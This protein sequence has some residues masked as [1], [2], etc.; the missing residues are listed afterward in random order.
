MQ[1]KKKTLYFKRNGFPLYFKKKW[2]GGGGGEN[3]T[4]GG[5]VE[6]H[7]V[8]FLFIINLVLLPNPVGR[9]RQELLHA[10]RQAATSNSNPYLGSENLGG[11]PNL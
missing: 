6:S 7:I 9:F 4:K 11:Y 3:R 1:K 5:G 10:D 2:V 8:L